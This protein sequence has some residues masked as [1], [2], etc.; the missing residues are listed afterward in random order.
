LVSELCTVR[1]SLEELHKHMSFK[2]IM[3]LLH[4]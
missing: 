4:M 2:D 1:M 3:L